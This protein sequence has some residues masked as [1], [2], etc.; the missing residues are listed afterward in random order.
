MNHQTSPSVHAI[1]N[2]TRFIASTLVLNAAGAIVAVCVL[3]TLLIACG[4]AA[5]LP[6]CATT[7]GK[8]M[9][10]HQLTV[11]TARQLERLLY[12][13]GELGKQTAAPS[14]YAKLRD[15]LAKIEHELDSAA[16]LYAALFKSP[17]KEGIEKLTSDLQNIATDVAHN[18]HEAVELLNE[19]GK[20]AAGPMFQADP[21]R[22]EQLKPTWDMNSLVDENHRPNRILFGS[23]G[24]VGD[25]RILPLQFDFGSGVYSFIVPMA[26]RGKLDIATPPNG[27]LD[28]VHK[29]MRDH[30]MGYHYWAGVYNNQNT[31]VADWFVKEFGKDDDVWMK[32][33][34]GKV[35]R[36]AP[37]SS[38]GQPN[39]WNANVRD[40]IQNY[41]E[42]QSKYFHVDPSLLCY[43]YAGE[44]HPYAMNPGPHDPQYSG[45]NA[46][47]VAEFRKFLQQKFT[48]IEKL[49]RAWK[50][51]YRSFDEIQ[52]PP[53]AYATPSA[54]AT[55]LSYEFELFRCQSHTNY[56]KLVYDG[57]RKYDPK[58]PIEAHASMYMNG[59]P[60]QAMD[61]YQMLKAGVADW[62][63]MHQNNF[64]P[65]LPEQIYLYSICRL[66][67]RVPVEFEYIWTFPRSGIFDASKESDFRA[68]CQSSVWRNLVWGKQALVF[69]DFYFEWPG[70]RNG[71]FDKDLG[72][73]IFRRSACVIP[74]IKRQAL[75]FSDIF[76][77]TEVENP[78]I[79][80][81]QPSASIWNSP[82]IHPHDGFSFHTGAAM[83]V[84]DLLYPH[85]YPFLYVPEEAVLNDCYQLSKHRAIILPQAPYLPAA[86]TDALLAWVREGGTLICT[87]LPGIWT[88]YGE[89]DLRLLNQVF[90][91]REMIDT[92]HGTWHWK[93]QLLERQPEVQFVSNDASGNVQLAEA[94]F[95]KG[96][97]LIATNGFDAS[98]D[99]QQFYHVLDRAIGK[100]SVRCA[101]D[102]FELTIRSGKGG[103]YLCV[104]NPDTREI[105]KDELIVQGS[106]RD[107]QD[108]GIGS[109]APLP[110]HNVDGET[111]FK[112]RLHPGESTM[113]GLKP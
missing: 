73:S 14:G 29:W 69:F 74:A 13:Q 23:T 34:D 21:V 62:I 19:A 88:P 76:L 3:C 83:K 36:S 50:S 9:V 46:S 28:S 55:P 30:K 32:L 70:Y 82:P 48:S 2:F 47:A 56:W 80:V 64:P 65:N 17:S 54:K 26:A 98:D 44:P 100:R 22:K 105:H 107:C 31:Y 63:D 11:A 66:T 37:G 27:Q 95:G 52:P 75:R 58:K 10:D 4:V 35:L 71:L 79:A 40:Y 39:I 53:D 87:G 81:L 5:D 43:D 33:A 86:M 91:K 51:S 42:T 97:V 77:N 60:A 103:R 38:W 57:Y 84:H 59:W 108:L 106:Y 89:N 85:N 68:T 16:I 102:A 49:N 112:L 25:D 113:I 92:D 99:R 94:R 1:R 111:R 20:K 41:C 72:Y 78:P 96:T 7:Y 101:H 61:A 24:R 6:T 109:G 110:V 104:L 67:H 18:E 8:L 45:Y 15:S 93:W 12:Y 90:S